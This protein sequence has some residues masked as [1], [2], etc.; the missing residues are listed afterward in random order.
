MH[1]C[2]HHELAATRQN[3]NRYIRPQHLMPR[4]G[5]ADRMADADKMLQHARALD[6]EG[7]E[8]ECM[9]SVRNAKELLGKR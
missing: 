7:K 8:A 9:T 4:T 5:A 1:R 3:G 6:R 2:N